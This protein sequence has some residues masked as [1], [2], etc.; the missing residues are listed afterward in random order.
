MGVMSNR[1]RVSDDHI[2]KLAAC[3]DCAS[4]VTIVGRVGRLR[5]IVVT[6][7]DTCLWLPVLD[8]RTVLRIF[9]P[10]EVAS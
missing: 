5:E 1:R 3:P 2:A 9:T 8:G 4:R 6:H 10:D 7:D